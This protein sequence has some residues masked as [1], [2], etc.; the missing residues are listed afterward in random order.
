MPDKVVLID[1][2]SLFHRA[3]HALPPLT[4]RSGQ[5]TNA[6]YGF[7]QML[8]ALLEEERP[9]YAMVA[10]DLPGPTFRD[11][12]YEEY[13]SHRPPTD[14]ALKAQ[15][16]LLE[17][18]IE[19][20]GMTAIGVDEYEADDV[21]GTLARRAADEGKKVVI[22]TGDRD[23]LQ[24][25]DESIEVL[26]TLRGIKQTKRY[27][28]DEVREDYG[29]APEQ[30]VDLKAL[31]GDSSDNIPGVPGIGEKSAQ[32]ILAQ[33]RS[34]EEAV[35][36]LDEIESG[37]IRSRLEEAPEQALM[38]KDLARIRTDVPLEIELEEMRWPGLRVDQ[39]RSL[40]VELEFTSLLERLPRG[41]NPAREIDARV[42]DSREQMRDMIERIEEE[43]SVALALTA[44]KDGLVLALGQGEDVAWLV[45]LAEVQETCDTL[46][47]EEA[48]PALDLGELQRVLADPQ[49]DKRAADLKAV[50]RRLAEMGIPLKGAEFDPEIASYLLTPNRRDHS[51]GTLVQE[52]LGYALIE[53]DD[54]TG[55][56]DLSGKH[57]R[58]AAEAVATEL[59]REPLRTSL[60]RAGLLELFA[61]VEMPLVP[62]LACMELA[63]IAV[64]TEKLHELGE[65][66]EET[67]GGLENQIHE[68]AGVEFNVGSPQ[69]LSEVL[70]ER[71][72][73]P[74][75]R[76]TKTG[77]S[78]SAAVL[79]ELAEEHEIARLVLECRSYSKL[80]STYVDGL[81][82]E[83]NPQTGRIHTTFEQTVAATGRLSSRNP[84]LQNIPIRTELGREIRS[85]FISE[86]GRMLVAADYSQIE[87]RI[88]AHISG[89]DR[90]VNAFSEGADI[91]TETASAL[92]DVK[93]EDCTYEMR[94]RAKTVNYAV[95]YGQG[96]TA[97]GKQLGITRKEAEEF[98]E[99]YFRA[100]PG[101]RDYMDATIGHAREHGYVE[102]LLGRKR[103]LPEIRS[104]DSRASSY[105]ERAAVNTPIQGSA[106]DI[107]KLAMIRLDPKLTER[108]PQSDVLLQVHD[109]LVLEAPEGET[110]AVAELVREVMSSAFELSVPLTVDVAVGS[111]WRDMQTV[112]T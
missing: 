37:R 95:L 8:M 67:I 15:V 63:G 65:G 33:F 76:K 53:E 19:A 61:D 68:I 57:L 105:A 106:A 86:P 108:S 110:D 88:L 44:V 17:D 34:V 78:T 62:I 16:S 93:P 103:P 100:L 56:D 72:E 107:M 71:M 1:G 83:V 82:K 22:V 42:I 109:E 10:L 52:H 11:E 79:E 28:V 69:Q 77:W 41:E 87:L 84:N 70:F 46:F 7:L 36:N 49:I 12:I 9:E 30:L 64:D 21:I 55:S 39:L 96:P 20:L 47:A 58:A 38:S 26:A 25:V 51:I 98:I 81:L 29:F 80:C 75:G 2:H 74:K 97:L 3:F 94:G 101:V 90:L 104:S 4:T 59:L 54:E 31:S 92:F 85:C 50:I 23:L 6:V 27:D 48:A 73:L 89:D 60:D 35:E 112:K 32:T 99:N 5:P 24:L 66:F 91:H 45:Q 13:K 111:N 14:E 40:A 102:T 18:A 43:G